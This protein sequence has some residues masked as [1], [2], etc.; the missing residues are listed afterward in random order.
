[1]LYKATIR[2]TYAN[3]SDGGYSSEIRIGMGR[4]PKIA[5]GRAKARRPQIVRSTGP[6]DGTPVLQ[7][8]T[9]HH[10]HKLLTDECD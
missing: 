10:G 2:D 7:T 3:C 9:L 6:A 4:S 8:R 1:M 5:W